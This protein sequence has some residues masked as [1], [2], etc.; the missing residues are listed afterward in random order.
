MYN[1]AILLLSIS[2]VAT[3]VNAEICVFCIPE[4][5]ENQ[6]VL[7]SQYF[8]VLLDHKP[9]VPGHLI[10]IPKRHIV[11]AHELSQGEWSEMAE[12]IP[13]IT[14]VFSEFLDTD[15]YIILEKNG[16]NAFQQVPHVHF[17]LFPIHSEAWSDIFDNVPDQ[18][19]QED[20]EQQIVLFK[21]YFNQ[22]KSANYR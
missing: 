2:L 16:H 10:I 21:G 7:E 3:Y 8:H 4:I 12:I 20:F 9:R 5:I 17:H 6:K 13:K 15:D 19:H 1:L 14:N 18:L 22:N 11:K